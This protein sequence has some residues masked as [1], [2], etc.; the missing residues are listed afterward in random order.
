[1]QARAC[2]LSADRRLACLSIGY[3]NGFRRDKSP[4]A[5]VV[6]R[7]QLAPVIGKTSMNTLVVDVTDL[8]GVEVGDEAMVFGGIADA[9]AS[10]AITEKQFRTIMADL[11]ADWG[12]RNERI[13][14]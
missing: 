4:D 8:E 14:R 12:M 10:L 3:A 7:N 9:S 6:L 2:L 11:Y 5:A 13:F 1:M